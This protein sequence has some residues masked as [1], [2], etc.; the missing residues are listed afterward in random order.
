MKPA[1]FAP[2]KALASASLLLGAFC[3]APAFAV[4]KCT[5][6]D[7]THLPQAHIECQFFMGTGAYRN[8]NFT[9]AAASWKQITLLRPVPTAPKE[10]ELFVSAFNNLGFLYFYGKGVPPN[11]AAA[12]DYWRY[13]A[14]MGNEESAYHLC[15]AHADSDDPLYDVDKARVFC[16]QALRGYES[17]KRRDDSHEEIVGQL[18]KYIADLGPGKNTADHA[19]PS[20]K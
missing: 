10:K 15:H 17:A 14:R 3:M 1:M 6:E 9:A 4:P 16:Q 5:L 2:V 19:A 20:R 11:Q 13:A 12:M 8:K 18:K 7:L